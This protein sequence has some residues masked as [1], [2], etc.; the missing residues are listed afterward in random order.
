MRIRPGQPI[1]HVLSGVIKTEEDRFRAFAVFHKANPDVYVLFKRFTFEVIKADS[2]V[3]ARLIG[4][5]IRWE[6]IVHT[7]RTDIYKLN[8]NHLPY[9]ARLFMEDFPGHAGFFET[10]KKR[11]ARVVN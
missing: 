3:G 6:N 5:R 1:N 10:R 2:K 7:R 11:N 8:N 4:E 9:Y